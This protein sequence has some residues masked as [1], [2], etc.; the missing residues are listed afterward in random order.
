MNLMF[1]VRAGELNNNIYLMQAGHSS[2]DATF[3]FTGTA[4]AVI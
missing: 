1:Q 3:Y 4:A 2:A